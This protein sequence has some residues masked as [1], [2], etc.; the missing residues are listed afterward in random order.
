MYRILDH[1]FNL[2]QF[3]ASTYSYIIDEYYSRKGMFFMIDDNED[4]FAGKRSWSLIK[5]QI[6][7][8]YMNIYIPK[9]N[10]LGRQILL[11]DAYA[12]PGTFEDQQLG[13]PCI[14]CEA[15]EKYAKEN[16]NAYFI[17]KNEEYHYKLEKTLQE[18]GWSRSA[19]ALLA[20][21]HK[22]LQLL[23]SILKDQT[24]FLYFDPFGLKGCEFSLLEPFLTRNPRFSTEILLT[25]NMPVVHRL[26]SCNKQDDQLEGG[27]IESYRERLTKVFGGDYW[28]EILCQPGLRAA[29]KEVKLINAYSSKLKQ[30]LRFTGSCPVRE[31]IDRRNKYFI[32]FAS[33]HEDTL[34]LLNDIMLRA[35]MSKMHEAS[36]ANTLFEEYS[37]QDM[38]LV[39]PEEKLQKVILEMVKAHPGAT[40]KT[41]WLHII[42]KYFMRYLESDFK[43]EV[44]HLVDQK[45][46]D[47][48]TPRKTRSLND[49]CKLY[50]AK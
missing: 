38:P 20:D 10:K 7:R 29:E 9:V 35:Y 12:G 45:K 33:R 41:L 50:L 36:Y 21:S 15:A 19:H 16:Y 22:L 31:R 48:P 5:D 30:Y 25:M 1:S 32:V 42:Q 34:F 28:K 49:D 23:P 27:R 17:N 47:C 43:K 8:D 14:M 2:T 11:I 18:R 37:W 3:K 46:L 44:L 6:L 26:A 39:E 40:R 13:S 24:V 4:F